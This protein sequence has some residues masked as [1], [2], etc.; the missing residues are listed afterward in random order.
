MAWKGNILEKDDED[1]QEERSHYLN[2]GDTSDQELEDALDS[3]Q[4]H[5]YTTFVEPV[6]E[7]GGEKTVEE[8]REEIR[9]PYSE[10]EI[11]DALEYCVENEGLESLSEYVSVKKI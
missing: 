3:K 7:D 6:R 4:I 1:E 10:E 11:R 5:V 2:I 9:P 8:L